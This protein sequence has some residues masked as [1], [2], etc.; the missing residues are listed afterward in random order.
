MIKLASSL[1]ITSNSGEF[2]L[3]Y[4]GTEV[5]SPSFRNL[6]GQAHTNILIA[7]NLSPGICTKHQ[8]KIIRSV[9]A[10]SLPLCRPLARADTAG[11][12]S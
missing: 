2:E 8:L 10:S 12:R 9:S 3:N 6:N 11:Q 5:T 1:N 7:S 4:I